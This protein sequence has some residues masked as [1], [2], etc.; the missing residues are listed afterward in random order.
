MFHI[1]ERFGVA[2][3]R[4]GGGINLFFPALEREQVCLGEAGWGAGEGWFHFTRSEGEDLVPES[5]Q[6]PLA[7]AAASLPVP[8]TVACGCSAGSSWSPRFPRT[9][10]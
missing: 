5:L 7:E 1:S 6:G 8:H 3:L 10:S 9:K 2:Y 4:Q